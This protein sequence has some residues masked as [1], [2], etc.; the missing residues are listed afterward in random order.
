MQTRIKLILACLLML[1]AGFILLFFKYYTFENDH[2]LKVSAPIVVFKDETSNITVEAKDLKDITVKYKNGLISSERL[3]KKSR[4]ISIPFKANTSGVEEVEI[5]LNGEMRSFEI[6]IC[7]NLKSNQK[8]ELKI[9]DNFDLTKELSNDCLSEYNYEIEDSNIISYQDGKI[10]AE[11][12]GITKIKFIRGEKVYTYDIEV[13]PTI[14]V[15]SFERDSYKVNE[16]N[17]IKTKVN[18]EPTNAYLDI[19][20]ESD[21][22]TFATAKYED[23][24]CVI[25]GVKEGNIE[26]KATSGSVETK[27]NLTIIDT[28]IKVTSI[29]FDKEVIKLNVGD[30]KELDAK[31]LP[32]NATHK[33]L[34]W[35]S[36]NS[37]IAEVDENGKVTAKNDGAVLITAT[38]KNGI[39]SSIS[40][41]VLKSRL[42]DSY[43]G[44]TLAYWI[45][46]PNQYY[47][48][49]HIWVKDSY[50]QLKVAIPPK[51]SKAEYPRKLLYPSELINN[52]IKSEKYS[53]KA[54]V[55]INAS[56][57]IG[58]QFYTD[59]PK[60][61][62]GTAASVYVLNRGKE[63]RNSVNESLM[64]VNINGNRQSVSSRLSRVVNGITNDGILKTYQFNVVNSAYDNASIN[65]NNGI[66]KTIKNDGVKDTWG[67]V[68]EPI[69]KNGKL[70]VTKAEVNDRQAICQIDKNNF[71]IITNTTSIDSKGFSFTNLGN[72]MIKMNCKTVINLDGG[73][74]ISYY[75]K[76]N[77]SKLLK[78]NT[79]NTNN[80]YINDML[81]FV[82]K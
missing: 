82:E 59:I 27:S 64:I 30:E 11:S 3:D 48:I 39:E 60:N 31:I 72:L 1:F 19:I 50:N 7:E 15:L 12:E 24:F 28:S 79:E 35:M 75:Y 66:I 4:K 77:T 52:E 40:I 46:E 14:K 76:K 5:S 38:S 55:A 74:S 32:T 68:N 73:G 51:V 16:S 43:T 71:I 41:V 36:S 22:E 78:I 13:K 69:V 34:I 8:I 21:D 18:Y 17:K 61:Y 10:V 26:V 47:K 80:R 9:N 44:K 2:L 45:E 49:T 70:K 63:I 56:A 23:G 37:D 6:L 33:K 20:C 29:T 57:A 42:V 67:F 53:N 65:A 81:Y 58:T 54:L 25:E 62:R